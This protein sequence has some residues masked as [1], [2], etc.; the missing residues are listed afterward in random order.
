MSD[1]QW[2]ETLFEGTAP[3]YERGRL[4]YAPGLVSLL[5]E[6][7]AADGQGRLL[8]VGCGPGTVAVPLAPLFREVV[9][10]DPD[11][12]MIAEAASRATAA[13]LGARTRWVR[14]RAEELPGGL[15]R[16][17]VAVF[18][19]SFHWTER[20]R[21]A[22]TVRGM[23]RPAGV[24]VHV[25]DLKNDSRTVDGLPYPAVPY[26]DIEELVKRYL[27]PVRRAGRGLLPQGTA[28]GEAAIL[29]DA[30]FQGPQRYVVPGGQE[31]RR[32]VD[33]V[34]AW[35]FSMSYS[36]PHLFGHRREAFETDLCRLLAQASPAGLFSEC[37]PS[38]EVFVWPGQCPVSLERSL[39]YSPGDART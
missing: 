18:A 11:A 26:R 20:E 9:G 37:A 28:G 15:G 36:A 12:G 21:V 22:K 24:L 19:Q 13:G 30:G 6:V 23:L 39:G 1:W 38:T 33:D 4:P 34:V 16:F 35:T 7:L 3:Y 32:T 29:A 2:D 10:V 31:L 14:M 25:A 5:A 17:D 8:D 27:G